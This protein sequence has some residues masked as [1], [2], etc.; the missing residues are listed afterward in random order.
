MANF[1]LA[2]DQGT[3]STRAIVFD[4]RRTKV[5]QHQLPLTTY[6]PTPGWVEQDAEQIWQTTLD[7]CRIAVKQAQLSFRDIKA[8]GITNQRE[9]TIIWD[10]KT[11]IPIY[12]AIVWQDRRTAELCQQLHTENCETSLQAK[13]GLLL[14]P[15]FSATK[16]NWL[17]DHVEGAR[18]R[19]ERGELAFGTIDSFLLWRLT[20]SRQH[21]TDITNA[22]RTSLFNIHTQQWDTD[23]LQLFHIPESLLPTVVDNNAYFGETDRSWFDQ[24]I[25]ITA[26]A[27]DQ[28]A[29][30]IGQSCFQPGMLKCTYGTGAFLMLNTGHKAK[31]STSRLLTTIAYRV[32]NQISYALEGSIFAAGSIVQWLR[33]QL[34]FMKTSAES[35]ALARSVPDNGGVYLVPAFTGLGAPY[36]QP[37]VRAAIT[38]LSRDSQMAHIVRAGLEAVAYQTRDLLSAMLATKNHSLTEVRVDGGMVVNDWLVQFLADTLQMAIKRPSCYETT[39]LGVASLAGAA[40]GCWPLY[41]EPTSQTYQLFQPQMSAPLSDELYLQWQKAVHMLIV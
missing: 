23:L 19:A 22:S 39:A 10:R 12:H 2:I 30:L 6:F 18:Q 4:S 33:D 16:I 7:C 17:L 14:D 3:T 28:Q 13:T 24:A 27:G 40:V 41:S 15:Y 5:S 8:I 11:S 9:T 32:D 36:W 34:K 31:L 21:L 26:M 20:Q 37:Q 35:E 1:I 38:G 29:A 25:P